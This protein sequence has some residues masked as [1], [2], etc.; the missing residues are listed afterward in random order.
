MSWSMFHHDPQHTGRADGHDVIYVG[1][2]DY[3]LY[4]LNPDGSLRW[5]YETGDYIE[6][7]PAIAPDGT[8]YVGS[9][10]NYLYALNPDGSLKWRYRTDGWVWSSPAVASDGTIYVGSGDSY[11]HALNPDG[12]LRWKYET[13]DYIESSP[14]IVSLDGIYSDWL[15]FGYLDDSDLSRVSI[16]GRLTIHRYSERPY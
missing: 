11:L 8:I 10:D 12:S 2:F 16:V 15:R 13:G 9:F 3:C 1:S 14:A 4:A 5:K 6:S 7:S